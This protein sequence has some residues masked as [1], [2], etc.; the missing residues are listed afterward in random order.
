MLLAPRDKNQKVL[1][2]TKVLESCSQCLRSGALTIVCTRGPKKSKSFFRQVPGSWVAK[3]NWLLTHMAA[4]CGGLWNMPRS[5]F[6]LPAINSPIHHT[7]IPLFFYTP[8]YSLWNLLSFNAQGKPVFSIWLV[9]IS[10]NLIWNYQLRPWW[11]Q[12]DLMMMALKIHWKVL[13]E[14]FRNILIQGH[15]GHRKPA[16]NMH[17]W[18][19]VMNV[20]FTFH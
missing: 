18:G 4:R 5:P 10:G 7:H 12:I 16:I 11:A 2:A 20:F 14:E 1:F 3:G 13:I 17:W 6:Y 19:K 9:A 8:S 15:I